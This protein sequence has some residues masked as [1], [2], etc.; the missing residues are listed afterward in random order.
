MRTDGR[1]EWATPLSVYEEICQH[2]C[3]TPQID[4]FASPENAK[5]DLWF[6]HWD[7]ALALDWVHEAEKHGR[8]LIFWMNP[9][10]SQPTMTDAIKKAKAEAEK[11]A[12]T[13]FLLPAWPDQK[14]YHELIK[15][16]PHE[17]T[18]GRIKFE[19]PPGIKPS[20]PRYGNIHGVIR[21]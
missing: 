14:W 15:G 2:W 16:H 9:P 5:C 18:R 8:E 19:P 3:R 6:T 11:G 1:D 13:L 12:V 4:T 7:N 17:F 21:A 10:Y 20:T